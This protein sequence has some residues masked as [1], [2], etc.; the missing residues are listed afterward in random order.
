[1]EKAL[2]DFAESLKR[3]PWY[4]FTYAWRGALL[5]RLGR[6]EEALADLDTAVRLDPSYTFSFNERFQAKR[7]L[8]DFEGAVADLNHAFARDPKYTW[9][10]ARASEADPARRAELLKSLD[11]AVAQ[12]PRLAWVRAW[13]GFSRLQWGEPAAA[14]RDLDR[15][16]E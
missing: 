12:A 1:P 4:S 9:L 8:K 16:A 11:E 3:M 7:G 5:N 2:A 14:I 15:A 10:G 13:R 6:Y